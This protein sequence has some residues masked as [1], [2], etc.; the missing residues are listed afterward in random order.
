ME[1]PALEKI[2]E[3]VKAANSQHQVAQALN[4]T[5]SYLH[6]ILNEKRGISA[7][8]AE[9]LG[10]SRETI[11]VT[12]PISNSK[13]GFGNV[14]VVVVEAT[15]VQSIPAVTSPKNWYVLSDGHDAV[16]RCQM[17]K[18][19]YEEAQKKAT[20]ETDGNWGWYPDDDHSTD[21]IPVN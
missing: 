11:Y 7:A 3:M 5:D 15:A 10:F 18:D 16:K 9:K 21:L 20:Q 4:I 17:T 12:L 14:D 2:K 6:D 8:V 13:S 1:N 19:E